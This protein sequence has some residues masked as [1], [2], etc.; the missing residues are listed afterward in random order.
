M[1]IK[2]ELPGDFLYRFLS[3]TGDALAP[4]PLPAPGA[5]NIVALPVPSGVKPVTGQL[6]VIDTGRGNVARLPVTTA[7][8]T[9][10]NESSFKYVQAVTVPVQSKGRAVTG[11]QVKLT[12]PASKYS[13]TVLLTPTH[14]GVA[15]FENVPLGEKITVEV[16]YGANPA[17]SQSETLTLNHPAEGYRWQAFDL[18]WPDVKT[19]AAPIAPAA[20]T[21]PNAAPPAPSGG[22]PSTL[23]PVAGGSYDNRAAQPGG[24]GGNSLLS[25]LV[26]LLVLGGIGYGLYVA[27]NTGRLKTFLDRLG[28]NTTTPAADGPAAPNPFTTAERTPIQPI[29]EGTADPLAGGGF[30][31]AAFAPIVSAGP[32]LVATMGTYAGSIFPITGPTADIGREPSN[33]IALPNDTNTSRRHATIQA[34]NGQ[35]CVM[36][37]S[38]SNGTFVN[39]VR[40]LTQ[41]PHL[42]R[43]GDEINIGGTRFRFEA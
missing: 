30:A 16:S 2:K 23:P 13:R 20:A 12:S 27:Y 42:L 33:M 7:G 25:T 14:N 34:D 1:Q 35:Y 31:G 15:T 43:T 10:L 32:R 29:T 6:E 28:I 17:K 9:S 11:V 39:G 21:S 8:A 36:D 26:S 41:T 18:D 5:D 19:V 38:S 4:A 3:G 24:G 22:P 40:I 37:N